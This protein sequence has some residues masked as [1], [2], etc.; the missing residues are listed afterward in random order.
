M[1]PNFQNIIVLSMAITLS[2]P[3]FAQSEKFG[4]L[5]YTVPAGWK[6]TKYQDGARMSPA[7][8]PPG[9]YLA[10]QVMKPVEFAGTIEQALEKIYDETCA[11]LK[12]TKMNE[13]KGGN[14][15]ARESKK[16]FRG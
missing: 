6:L 12:V 9:E 4:K 11:S 10:I 13:V 2:Q 1:K 5:I 7:D 14:Y 16:S 15:T 3:A 8:L